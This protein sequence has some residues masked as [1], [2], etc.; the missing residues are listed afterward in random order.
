MFAHLFDKLCV[1]GSPNKRMKILCEDTPFKNQNPSSILSKI[2]A[3]QSKK[4]NNST[5]IH[6]PFD[7]HLRGSFS[8][9]SPQC[10]PFIFNTPIK[11][12]S[13]LSAFYS[14]M[15]DYRLCSNKSPCDT[16]DNSISKGIYFLYSFSIYEK[17]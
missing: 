2:R 3:Q 12:S 6:F 10:Q 4:L 14:P 8:G 15:L 17:C 9:D 1:L 7:Q 11:N 5:D 13:S 16:F